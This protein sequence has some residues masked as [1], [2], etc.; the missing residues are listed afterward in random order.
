MATILPI[1]QSTTDAWSDLREKIMPKQQNTSTWEGWFREGMK[2]AIYPSDP[3]EAAMSGAMGLGPAYTSGEAVNT[4]KRIIEDSL[5]SGGF[6][7]A[8]MDP[9]P[10]SLVK[11]VA[12]IE[13]GRST[14]GGPI[15]DLYHMMTNPEVLERFKK[16]HSYGH[17]RDV[18]LE[19]VPSNAEFAGQFNSSKNLIKMASPTNSSPLGSLSHEAGHALSSRP[20]DRLWHSNLASDIKNKSGR[21]IVHGVWSSVLE[22]YA[23]AVKSQVVP[24]IPLPINIS[25]WPELASMPKDYMTH[26]TPQAYGLGRQNAMDILAGRSPQINSDSF[27]KIL[28][29]AHKE[30]L[31]DQFLK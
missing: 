2:E 21:D 6:R 18:D 22:P 3:R 26:V 7:S 23:E 13:S 29:S 28:E 31:L 27:I 25:S 16:F 30:G 9:T 1:P 17:F 10:K 11:E 20:A 12:G 24:H 4:A 15:T 14:F 5:R 8:L 19:V